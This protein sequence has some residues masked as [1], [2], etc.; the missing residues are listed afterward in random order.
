MSTIPP[1]RATVN[2]LYKEDGKAE[3]IGGRMIRLSPSGHLPTLVA[4]E[5][6]YSLHA[7]SRSI[8][9][10]AAYTGKLAY[11]VPVLSSGRKSFSPHVSWYDG[12]LPSNRMHFIEGPPNLAIEVR[13][14]ND[15]TPS[16][17]ANI[18]AKR[19]DYFQAGTQ[20]VWDVD[21]IAETITTYRTVSQTPVVFHRGD[22]ADAEPAV[23]GRRVAV[24]D[25]FNV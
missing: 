6:A 13:S 20:V 9:R 17:E 1:D 23:P 10:G 14:E 8:G 22:V 21:P 2:D 12:P 19:D 3:L 18:A 4:G 16:A 7:H 15:Y 5:I 25:V 11:I 24:A